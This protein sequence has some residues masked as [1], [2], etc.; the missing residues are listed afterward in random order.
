MADFCTA[1]LTLTAMGDWFLRCLIYT[2]NGLTVGDVTNGGQLNPKGSSLIRPIKCW[3]Q[4]SS[5]GFERAL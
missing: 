5:L 3:E 1:A 4:T 2:I